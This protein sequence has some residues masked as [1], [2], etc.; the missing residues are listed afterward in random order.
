M[1]AMGQGES[2][3]PLGS[4]GCVEVNGGWMTQVCKM[5]VDTDTQ[6]AYWE[7]WENFGGIVTLVNKNGR[8]FHEM[9]KL[10]HIHYN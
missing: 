3:H 9:V 5:N 10:C 1:A 2:G 8:F 7:G 6:W 4:F